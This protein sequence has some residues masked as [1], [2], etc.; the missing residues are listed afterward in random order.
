M[1][2]IGEKIIAIISYL[3]FGI[4]GVLILFFK[5]NS[6]HFLRFHIYQSLVFSLVFFLCQQLWSVAISIIVNI[7]K[8]LHLSN[9]L[10]MKIFH[11]GYLSLELT[12]I[13]VVIY[14]IVGVILGKY[15]WI[16]NISNNIYNSI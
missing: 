16:S 9:P 5:K 13:I 1:K 8:A 2:T 10:L 11:Y 3:S 6:T 15:S 14:C 7:L 12:F 4:A